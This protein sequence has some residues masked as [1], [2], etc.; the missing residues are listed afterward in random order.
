MT[1]IRMAPPTK[2]LPVVR[3]VEV[4]VPVKAP[5]RPRPVKHAPGVRELASSRFYARRETLPTRMWI[6]KEGA[7]RMVRLR[8]SPGPPAKG[9]EVTLSSM[10][11]G[12]PPAQSDYVEKTNEVQEAFSGPILAL[13]SHGTGTN[14]VHRYPLPRACFQRFCFQTQPQTHL[15]AHPKIFTVQSRLEKSFHQVVRR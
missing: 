2:Y 12:A 5:P 4:Q 6:G 7:A 10:I 3:V 1:E 9:K 11:P 13:G 8:V 14:F 15:D